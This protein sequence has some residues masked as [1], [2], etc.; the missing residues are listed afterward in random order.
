MEQKVKNKKYNINNNK[1]NKKG[2]A[3]MN[4]EIMIKK[5][6]I[7][8]AYMLIIILHHGYAI[9]QIMNKHKN[10]PSIFLWKS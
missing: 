2:V 8:I 10:T 3:I 9:E 1:Y 7:G 6:L 4:N 5:A